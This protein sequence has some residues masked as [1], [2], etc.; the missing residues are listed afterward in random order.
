MPRNNEMRLSPKQKEFWNEPYHRWNI[1]YG[2]TRSG[3][4]YLDYFVILR[5][6]RKRTGLEGQIVFLGNTKGT[7]QRNVIEPMQ[8]IYGGTLSLM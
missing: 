8:D 3:K 5:E 4:T 2:A 1:K 7:L 6:I